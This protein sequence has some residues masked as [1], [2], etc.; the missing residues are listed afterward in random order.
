MKLSTKIA[1]SMA[2]VASVAAIAGCP[3]VPGVGSSPTPAPTATPAPGKLAFTKIAF[4]T[5]S[6]TTNFSNHQVYIKN[7]GG[8]PISLSTY[9]LVFFPTV[10][11]TTSA[12]ASILDPNNNNQPYGSLPA[13]S[14]LQVSLSG[15]S[16]A[17]GA[18]S[19]SFASGTVQYGAG[20][21]LSLYNSTTA[22]A[23][24]NLVDFVEWIKLPA[25]TTWEANAVPTI[26]PT[27]Q[28][29]VA[30]ASGTP[31][32][33]WNLTATTPGALGTANGQTNWTFA[34]F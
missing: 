22:T 12:T 13:G 29:P 26:W 28:T 10:G 23:S 19:S 16:P 3:G 14:T 17:T 33:G 27:A 6:G 18:A 7:I 34:A 25:G 9:Q 11:S 32:N 30:T 20:G 8:L 1:L 21:S 2:G 31:T 15:A 5:V 4:Y 24:S